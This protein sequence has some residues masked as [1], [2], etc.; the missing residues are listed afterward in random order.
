MDVHNYERVVVVSARWSASRRLTQAGCDKLRQAAA[1]MFRGRGDGD[2]AVAA[3]PAGDRSR[4]AR[5]PRVRS[6]T[7]PRRPRT[8]GLEHWPHARRCR[9]DAPTSQPRPTCQTPSSRRPAARALQRPTPP[10]Q[11]KN[12]EAYAPRVVVSLHRLPEV[13]RRPQRLHLGRVRPA[14]L[15]ERSRNRRPLEFVGPVVSFRVQ[16]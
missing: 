4:S 5:T 1:W 15:V 3:P 12:L 13:A 6:S 14:R 16:Y 10:P 7:R 8:P 2:G 11:N 9:R